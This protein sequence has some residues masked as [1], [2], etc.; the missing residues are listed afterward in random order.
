MKV[1]SL[2][3]HQRKRKGRLRRWEDL[4][5]FPARSQKARAAASQSTKLDDRSFFEGR[6][7]GNSR[8]GAV[9]NPKGKERGYE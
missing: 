4:F 2:P 9:T 3:L 5:F 8:D 6:S 1:G 7:Q